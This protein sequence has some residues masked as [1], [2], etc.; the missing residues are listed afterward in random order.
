MAQESLAAYL[1]S[2]DTDYA[3]YAGVLMAAGFR[4]PK[5]L[6]TVTE[7]D[8]PPDVIPKG[9]VR[10][11]AKRAAAAQPQPGATEGDPATV[12]LA[13]YLQAPM[14]DALIGLGRPGSHAV[15]FKDL[16]IELWWLSQ[17]ER[18]Q[19]GAYARDALGGAT[20]TAPSRAIQ[21]DTMYGSE[22]ETNDL[23]FNEACQRLNTIYHAMDTGLVWHLQPTS[24]L[25]DNTVPDLVL[26][27]EATHQVVMFAEGKFHSVLDDPCLAMAFNKYRAGARGG[28]ASG[29]GR[30]SMC[31]AVAQACGYLESD[32]KTG[33]KGLGLPYGFLTTYRHTFFIKRL[34]RKHYAITNAFLPTSTNPSVPEMLFYLAGQARDIVLQASGGAASS[35]P[36][37]ADDPAGPAAH[38]SSGNPAP[39]N[40]APGNPAKVARTGSAPAGTAGGAQH[41]HSTCAGTSASLEGWPLLPEDAL[42]FGMPL[43]RGACGLV[44]E[45]RL[46]GQLAA[47]KCV[48]ACNSPDLMRYL[49]HEASVLSGRLAD[50]QGACVPVLHAAGFWRGGLVFLLATSRI[51][52][53]HP[54]PTPGSHAA[55]TLA[56]AVEALTAIHAH[57][58]LHGD[59]CEGNIIVT[60]DGKVVCS[61][62]V[63]G[64]R[65]VA[66][67]LCG[68]GAAQPQP[69]LRGTP[70]CSC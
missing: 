16:T 22:L 45:G 48:D 19:I 57:G 46:F 58:V 43:G 47:I 36:A 56:A 5:E 21:T 38:G 8:V 9:A 28:A 40:P 24:S 61:S 49:Q 66:R 59:V 3:Q 18:G 42:T 35:A 26:R 30:Q 31:C 4:T 20:M 6:A 62:N 41:T 7:A 17:A 54:H 37:P 27:I 11:I 14:P 63:Q 39:G 12:T 55:A 44:S 60:G 70:C 68:Q 13:A 52:G 33:A 29:S 50:L 51:I 10:L 25:A 64:T 65:V 32:P 67:W 23:F 69:M 2:I 53:T 34:A 1:A 15:E